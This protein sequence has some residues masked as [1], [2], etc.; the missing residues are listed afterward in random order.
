MYLVN[1]TNFE[2]IIVALFYNIFHV[3]TYYKPKLNLQSCKFC[4]NLFSL[5]CS[6]DYIYLLDTKRG[7]IVTIFA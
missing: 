6:Y 2:L 3:N 4:Y 1:N 5:I 7:G